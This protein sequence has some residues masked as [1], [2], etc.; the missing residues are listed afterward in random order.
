MKKAY[1]AILFTFTALCGVQAEKIEIR[2]LD[3]WDRPLSE[4][5]VRV[6]DEGTVRVLTDERGVA[7]IEAAEGSV[8]TLT[9]FNRQSR[10]VRVDAPQIE[11]R[12]TEE[13]LLFDI[14]YD[15]RIR[16]SESTASLSQAVA[17]DIEAS[18]NTTVM[19]NLYGLIPGLGVYQG[20][21]LP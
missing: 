3:S 18:G 11:V 10:T 20:S 12:L 15:E 4:V 6:G 8:L 13:D 2:V 14:G 9:L 16:K 21:N 7:E 19:N 5:A 1:L 17:R